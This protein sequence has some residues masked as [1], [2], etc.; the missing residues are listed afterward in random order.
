[1]AGVA[2]LRS[3]FL[4][5]KSEL[6]YNALLVMAAREKTHKQKDKK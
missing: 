4:F 1:M 6:F 2:I 3:G 5:Y